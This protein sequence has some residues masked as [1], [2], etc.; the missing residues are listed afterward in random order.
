MADAAFN[1]IQK[2]G[3]AKHLFD[4]VMVDIFIRDKNEGAQKI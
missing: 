3:F 1:E 2:I 4:G